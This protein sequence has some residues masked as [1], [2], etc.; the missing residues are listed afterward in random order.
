MIAG[1][2]RGATGA[3]L[4]LTAALA[5][6][7]GGSQPRHTQRET[8]PVQA[9]RGVR[10]LPAPHGAAADIAPTATQTAR[11]RRGLVEDEVAASAARREDPCALVS[12]AQ[13]QA[14]LGAAMRAPVLAPQGPTCIYSTRG[15]R[16]R[17]T[18]AIQAPGATLPLKALRDRMRV[19]VG[20]RHAYCGIA[21]A[22]TL[23]M[24]LGAGRL[25]VVAA[26]CPIAAAFAADA[27]SHASRGRR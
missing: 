6:G 19:R 5:A 4:A 1:A 17:V 25:I 9:A 3:M 20:D 23:L 18:L 22:P 13:A 26:P 2:A 21:G 24:P 11:Q 15:D 7:C 8:G 12:R 10:R 14:I 27:L 16:A